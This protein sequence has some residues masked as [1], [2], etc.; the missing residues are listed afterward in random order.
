MGEDLPVESVL[1]GLARAPD[2]AG[3]LARHPELT[4][5]DVR[6]CLT[7]AA[8]AVRE[9][10]RRRPPARGWRALAGTAPMSLLGHLVLALL[11]L[12]SLGVEATKPRDPDDAVRRICERRFEMTKDAAPVAIPICLNRESLAEADDSIG[13]AVLVIHGSGRNAV[14]AQAAVERAVAES[15]GHG[16]LIVAPQFPTKEDLDGQDAGPDVAAWK[17]SDWSQGDRADAALPAARVSS[18]DVLDLLIAD[19]SAPDRYPNL[20]DI[21]VAGHSAGGQFVHRY[22]AGTRIEQDAALA[23]RKL[24]VRYVVANPSSYLY[25]VPIHYGPAS[26][27]CKGVGDYKYGLNDLNTYMRAIGPEALRSSYPHK[28]VT[29]LLGRLDHALIDP[30]KDDTCEGV[31]Q[32]AHR[33]NRGVRFA[34]AVDDQYGSGNHKTRVVIVPGVGHSAAA[35]FTSPEGRGVLLGAGGGPAGSGAD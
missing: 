9:R 32:G 15:G 29:M 25:M 10:R 7:Y 31:A 5:D 23:E 22:A 33:L 12:G 30:S 28:D 27:D 8:D 11:L 19:I 13:M 21:I 35:M 6:A 2:L 14:S 24:R 4:A 16:V 3:V 1:E 26:S 17:A 34:R 20:R 18:F